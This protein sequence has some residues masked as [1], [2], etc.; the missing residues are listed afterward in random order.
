M[1]LAEGRALPE[2]EFS[3]VFSRYEEVV[4]RIKLSI[5]ILALVYLG[6]T[7]GFML[8]EHWDFIT[9]FYFTV[10]TLSTVGYGIPGDALSTPGM[11]FATAV[12]LSGVSVALYAFSNI[13]ALMVEGQI[14][15]YLEVRRIMKEIS[16]LKDHVIIVG[17]GRTTTFMVPYLRG[18]GIPF[19]VIDIDEDKI[20]ELKEKTFMK[21]MLYVVGDAKDEATLVRAGVRTAGAIVLTLPDDTQNLFIALTARTL[22]PDIKVI[23]RAETADSMRKLRYAGADHVILP[24]EMAATRMASIVVG[25]KAIQVIDFLSGNMGQ[26]F[27]FGEIEVPE[28]SWLVGKTLAEAKIPSYVNVVIVAVRKSDG[29][30]HFNPG[31]D[32]KIEAGDTLIV[33]ADRDKIH[34]LEKL[35]NMKVRPRPLFR[36]KGS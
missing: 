13:T 29:T 33:I 32:Y 8:I 17:A 19:V 24:Q 2:E 16:E 11:I 23:S 9:A 30:T 35:V 12:I 25:E 26:M 4:R 21:R 15:G 6:A 28:K 7:L 10:I 36:R 3:A 14:T 22:N 31:A 18:Y 1:R 5:L 34:R 20:T 27:M